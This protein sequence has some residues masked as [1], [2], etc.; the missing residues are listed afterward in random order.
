MGQSNDT[1]WSTFSNF[2]EILFCDLWVYTEN[3]LDEKKLENYDEGCNTEWW[4]YPNILHIPMSLL[5]GVH[6]RKLAGGYF[7]STDNLIRVRVDGYLKW[8]DEEIV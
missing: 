6:C 7:F 2:I 8:Y 4:I 5:Q 3:L 1:R